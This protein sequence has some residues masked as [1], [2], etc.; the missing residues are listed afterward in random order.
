MNM[1][2]KPLVSVLTPVYNGDSFLG[3][4]IESVLT[5]TY[6][7][8]EYIIVNNCSTD[9]T[10]DIA[11]TYAQRDP[12]IR[13]H[14][15]DEFLAVIDNHNLAFSF[16][17]ADAKY[18]KVVSGD[19]FIF[20]DCLRQMV[21]CAERNP[22]VG[23][24][25]SYQLSGSYIKWQGYKYPQA[26][27]SGPDICRHMFL[28]RQEFIKGEGVLGFGSPSSLLYRADLI[29]DSGGHFY[30]N[31]SPHADTSACFKCLQNCDFGF[32]YQVLSYERTHEA[33]QTAT[34]KKLNRY[35]SATLNDL[36]Q[37]GPL[38]LD[39]K[40]L[41]AKVKEYLNAY[42]EL[43]ATNYLAGRRGDDFWKYH[44][45]RLEELG[46]PFS[47]GMLLKGAATRLVAEVASPGRAIKKVWSRVVKNSNGATR[48]G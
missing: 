11:L 42:Y 9:R 1:S 2:D 8:F 6:D 39:K 48:K 22:S 38:Y 35:L 41:E 37:Y 43:L 19:D 33:T 47:R 40:E 30:P 16:I 32:V 21:E 3:E 23:I 45:D 5:Q 17:S 26:V 31:S 29:R 13:V 25:G 46:Y 12:R 7:T 36:I 24:V 18:C 4:C 20:P 34:S 14:N 44:R 27:Y 15:N 28:L 10:Y